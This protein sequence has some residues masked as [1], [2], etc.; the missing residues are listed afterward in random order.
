[1]PS[2]RLDRRRPLEKVW[3]KNVMTFRRCR[4]G[5]LGSLTQK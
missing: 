1:M 4:A 3:G 2:G 5:S